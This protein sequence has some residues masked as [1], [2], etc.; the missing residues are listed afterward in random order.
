MRTLDQAVV[1]QD[2]LVRYGVT[3]KRRPGDMVTVRGIINKKKGPTVNAVVINSRV[4]G[5]TEEVLVATS[6]YG[7]RWFRESGSSFQIVNEA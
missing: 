3:A 1:D 7:R 2:D 6:E 5:R 4:A